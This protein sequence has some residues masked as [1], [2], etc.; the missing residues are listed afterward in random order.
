MGRGS[1]VQAFSVQ[2]PLTMAGWQTSIQEPY[3]RSV[4]SKRPEP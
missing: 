2:V 4:P 3:L 1:E